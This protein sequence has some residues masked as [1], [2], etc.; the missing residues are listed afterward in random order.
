[1]RIAARAWRLRQEA[2]AAIRE[3]DW[4]EAANLA[5]DACEELGTKEGEALRL[6]GEW[7]AEHAEG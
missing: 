5:S 6:I 1:M 7:M 4:D 2:R 3:G